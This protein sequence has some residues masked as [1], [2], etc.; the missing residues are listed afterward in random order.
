LAKVINFDKMT[1]I[2]DEEGLPLKR[3]F[4]W[5]TS[6]TDAINALITLS[7]AGSPEGVVIGRVG[8]WYVDTSTAPGTGMYYKQSGEGDTGWRLK[9]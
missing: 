9:S 3:I 5:M 8:Q 6:V 1:K 4:A 7:G 2:V